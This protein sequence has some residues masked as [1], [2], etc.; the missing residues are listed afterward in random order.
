[1]LAFCSKLT[2]YLKTATSL[3]AYVCKTE[4]ACK[5]MVQLQYVEWYV[6]VRFPVVITLRYSGTL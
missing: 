1:M 2:Y 3:V 6:V 4:N 5:P